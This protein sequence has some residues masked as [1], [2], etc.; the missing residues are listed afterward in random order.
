MAQT[1]DSEYSGQINQRFNP[2]NIQFDEHGSTK[3]AIKFA[4]GEKFLKTRT[5]GCNNHLDRSV[6]KHKK[7][8][9]TNNVD[10]FCVLVN[11]RKNS[12]MEDE[13]NQKKSRLTNLISKQPEFCQ[14]PLTHAR[15][16][17]QSEIKIGHGS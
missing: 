5:L 12:V 3:I 13:L 10:L 14:S 2:N 4:F 16:L 15:L 9:N 17:G 8:F 6:D 11:A 1:N 7:Y